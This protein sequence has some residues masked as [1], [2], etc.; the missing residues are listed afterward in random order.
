MFTRDRKNKLHMTAVLVQHYLPQRLQYMQ[1]QCHAVLLCCCGSL[2]KNLILQAKL[3]QHFVHT[4]MYFLC[5]PPLR[6]IYVDV[7]VM[8]HYNSSCQMHQDARFARMSM[9]SVSLKPQTTE[10]AQWPCGAECSVCMCSYVCMVL[11]LCIEPLACSCMCLNSCVGEHLW[12][13]TVH[14][15]W[16]NQI[17][18][19]K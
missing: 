16:L 1:T 12:V 3:W 13:S 6:F 19:F 9:S 2:I 10:M 18:P 7:A 17:N 8:T 5:H 11:W 4:V 14:L 15:H